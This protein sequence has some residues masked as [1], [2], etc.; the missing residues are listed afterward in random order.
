[1]SA[2]IKK[3]MIIFVLERDQQPEQC[4]WKQR[5]KKFIFADPGFL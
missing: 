5:R 4:S 1:M 3:R 2:D